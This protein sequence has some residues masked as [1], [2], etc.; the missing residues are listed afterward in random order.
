MKKSNVKVF[1]LLHVLLAVYSVSGIFS[2]IASEESFLSIKWCLCYAGVIGLLG[3]YA[4]GWQQII[5]RM[6]L[7][8][9]Y[10]NKAVTTVWGLIYGVLFFQEKV[11]PGKI[12]GVI[13]VVAG[14][15]LFGI[16]DSGDE[17]S[18]SDQTA[19]IKEKSESET[20]I[21]RSD[22]EAQS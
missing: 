19:P 22:K 1:I 6:P 16:A 15:A 10:A 11:T 4:I 7:T 9:A 13:L 8:A 14:V 20:T 21:E 5:K 2:K 12:A 18:N 3:V 17:S